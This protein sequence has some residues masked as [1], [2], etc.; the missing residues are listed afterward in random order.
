MKPISPNVLKL[1]VDSNVYLV[2][3]KI[4]IDTGPESYKETVRKTI[5]EVI[6]LTKI[7]K[8]IFTHL[9]YDHIGNFELFPNAEFFASEEAISDFKEAPVEAVLNSALVNKFNV[10]LNTLT[11]LEG[12]KII[13]TPGHT[14]GSI[15]LLYEK[16][17]VLFSGDTLF[18]KDN[19]GRLDLP[20]SVPEQMDDS[21]K[22]LKD[23]KTL[24]PGHDY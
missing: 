10:K 9:H 18:F 19:I 24:A 12:F 17:N 1:N 15:C 8:V 13:K 7:E 6:D 22:K 11:E 3:K 4:I 20:T 2:E 23:Y 21:L 14:K 5:S 16:D